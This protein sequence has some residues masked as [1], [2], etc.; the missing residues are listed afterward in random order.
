[1]NPSSCLTVFYWFSA[2]CSTL[3]SNF[4]VAPYIN[5]LSSKINFSK[6]FCVPILCFVIY[7]HCKCRV[8][9]FCFLFDRQC[10]F[11]CGIRIFHIG[12]LLICIH[13]LFQSACQLLQHCIVNRLYSVWMCRW[14]KSLP[15]WLFSL[16]SLK[17]LPPVLF[18]RAAAGRL[19]TLP[20]FSSGA[21]GRI[22]SPP[23]QSSHTTR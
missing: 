23:G 19:P 7:V 11:L 13:C 21:K 4:S 18:P 22:C 16:I 6:V 5:L 10:F 2:D 17:A 15:K 3:K 8:G 1:M 9:K 14:T 20:V 12:F